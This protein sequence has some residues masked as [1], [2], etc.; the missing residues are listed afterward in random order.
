MS[1]K[2]VR[3]LAL[4][5]TL[6]FL[7]LF[8]AYSNDLQQALDL[9]NRGKF[10][11]AKRV[12]ESL[13][14]QGR[15]EAPGFALLGLVYINTGEL[16]DAEGAI[17]LA[18]RLDPQEY[19]VRL[20]RAH[21]HLHREEYRR[22]EQ[23]FSELQE[24][25]PRRSEVLSGLAGTL[26]GQSLELI[27]NQEFE[28]AAELTERAVGL[29]PDNPRLLSHRIAVLRRTDRREELEQ[30]YRRL[31]ELQPGSGDAHA[32]LGVLLHEQGEREAARAYLKQAVHFD[33]VDPE[34]FLI[35]GR[36]AAAEGD[37]NEAQGLLQEAVGK[38]VQLFNMYRMQAA[39]E[40]D[41]RTAQD[42]EHLKRI[43]SLSDQSKRPKRL[44]EESLAALSALYS[45]PEELLAVVR[46]LA[47]WYSSST[48]VRTVLAEQLMAAGYT[49][50]AREEWRQLSERYPFYYRSHLGLAECYRREG[51]GTKAALAARRALDLAPE[52]P[53]VYDRLGAIYR[54]QGKPEVYLQVLELRI[55]KD[56]YNPLLYRKAAAAA[57]E[58]GR[59]EK[60]ELFRE[61]IQLLREYQDAQKPD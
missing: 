36:R 42:A 41:N 1:F 50:Q 21:L 34:P 11:Q 24:D 16:D 7:C 2:T 15:L 48:D 53:E 39:R 51:A 5:G 8:S 47:D 17:E 32:G 9:Y 25:Y 54:E 13:R 19:L 57:E 14:D 61:R 49:A 20:A 52:E 23:L 12:M 40:M 26:A 38:A 56:K 31:L 18:S 33:T 10:D 55:L 27:H 3:R 29:Q 37:T 35:L 58:L 28:A 6:L 4:A 30:A 59:S 43:Q 22:G 44:L 45:D 46:R 60:A